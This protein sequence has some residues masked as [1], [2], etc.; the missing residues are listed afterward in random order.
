MATKITALAIAHYA[1]FVAA[2]ITAGLVAFAGLLPAGVSPWAQAIAAFL[3][4]FAVLL[5]A[6][7]PAPSADPDPAKHVA[8]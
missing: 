8:E 3:G 5:V 4:A 2:L 7:A 6:N 1:K